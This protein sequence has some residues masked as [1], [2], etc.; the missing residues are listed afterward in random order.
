MSAE[1]LRARLDAMGSDPRP[2][3]E[4]AVT[5]RSV[6]H[7]REVAE[8]IGADTFSPDDDQAEP[9]AERPSLVT[10]ASDVQSRSIRWAWTGRLAVGYLTVITGVE[11]LGKSVFSA[12]MIARLTRG[13]LEGEWMGEPA[14]ALILAGEDGIADTWRPRLEL[15]GADLDRV[16]FLDLDQLAPGWNVRDGI[17]QLDEA[18]SETHAR[19]L[20]VDAALDHF[21][22]PKGGESVNS[23]TYVRQALG[24]LK[25]LV[26]DREMV[27]TFGLHPPKARGVNFRDLVQAS[28]AFSAIPRVGLLFDYHPDDDADDPDRRR[29]LLR[30]KGNIGPDPG[31]LTF[32]IAAKP[33]THDDGRTTDRETVTDVHVSTLTLADLMPEKM[34]GTRDATKAEQAADI[35]RAE[36]AGQDWY[37]AKLVREK[38]A[39]ANLDS[40]SVRTKALQLCGAEKRKTERAWWWRL[41]PTHHH[42][43]ND[44]LLDPSPAARA[45][46][47][48][49][50]GPLD[51]H[52][53][54]PS[55]NGKGPT[56]HQLSTTTLA[57]SKSPSPSDIAHAHESAA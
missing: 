26:R 17:E 36:L 28:Q 27:G 29:V 51:S 25:K 45:R 12:W 5:R 11:G 41:P 50:D 10:R 35:M 57:A 9:P 39:A 34:I 54:K 15:A 21:P 40:G 7:D 53:E 2:E 22:P 42:G 6:E 44:G 43:T 55:S 14:D 38:L 48:T 4:A 13:E 8:R 18:T 46:C 52:T 30:G 16:S 56:V 49:D 33:F 37:P 20:T 23:P 19:I 31:A 47:V 3:D 1:T 24:P 32:R